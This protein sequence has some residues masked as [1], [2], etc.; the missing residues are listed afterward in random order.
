MGYVWYVGYSSYLCEERFLCYILGGQFRW[1]GR[2]SKGCKEKAPPLANEVIVLPFPLYFAMNSE[3]WD[4]GGVAF[5]DSDFASGGRTLGR[6]WK[7]T[8]KQFD[9]L[10][11]QE[12]RTWYDK[13]VTLGQHN[14]GN[15]IITMTKSKRL[16]ETKPSDGYLKTIVLGLKETFEL[17]DDDASNYLLNIPGIEGHVSVDEISALVRSVSRS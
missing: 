15:K 9:C 2:G 17:S 13:E 7:V 1:G 14:D 12:G 3:S 11:S 10:R 6:M 16:S 8:S 4:N 5:I